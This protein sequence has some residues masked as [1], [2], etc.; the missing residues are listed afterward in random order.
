MRHDRSQSLLTGEALPEPT[1]RSL[2]ALLE[3]AAGLGDR[4]GVLLIDREGVE[5]L[6]SYRE[7]LE[8]ASRALTGLRLAGAAPGDR[9]VLQLADG[10]DLLTA[11]WACVLGG[12]V[13][14]PVSP[15]LPAAEVER[16]AERLDRPW[17]LTDS[18]LGG[19]RALPLD[20][21]GAPSPYRHPARWEDPALLVLTAG[22][23]GT[24]KAVVLS[25]RNVI[26]R[27][28]GTALANGLDEQSVT[29]N[30]MPLDHVSGLVMFHLRDVLTGSHQL[31]VAKEWILADP[32]RW[33]D[34]VHRHRVGV[35]WAV[36]SALDQFADRLA[37]AGRRDWD[38]SCLH[39]LMSGG[40]A[41]QAGTVRRFLAALT[42]YGLA[43]TALRPG[44]GMSET[45]AG[46]VDHRADLSRLDGT[47]GHL[48]VGRPQAGVAV[49][50]VDR[51]DRVLPEGERGRLQVA[52]PTVTSGYF[53]APDSAGELFTADGWL[54]TGDL[55]LVRDGVLT[56]TG[57][58]D[59]FIPL[60][61]GCHGYEIEAAVAELPFVA[62]RSVVACMVADGR[63][64][65][66][67]Y[68]Q[69]TDRQ[70]GSQH[71]AGG[72]QALRELV[73]RRFGVPVAHVVELPAD[74]IPR[75]GTGKPRRAVLRAGFD[76]R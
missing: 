61:A 59:D 1:V 21:A 15:A 9:V 51:D 58:S 14:A 16:I 19:P 71:H 10:K 75:T 73:D 22:S 45:A 12:L 65:A 39:Y 24:P 27:S 36:N 35:S 43:P 52:G 37:T 23:S 28:A 42:P 72:H 38:L 62:E 57:S 54:R 69:L 30:W 68:S 50:V 25:H 20:L 48:P 55:A 46:V 66:V 5:L 26:S 60:G 44:W 40:Q 74:Q 4:H 53:G 3:R 31:H 34:L 29:L 67:F 76:R 17:L 13:P 32:L 33:M 49:R 64:L 7:L 47:E 41:V 63:E 2:P 11:F 6:L 56:V 18:G 70:A 8:L